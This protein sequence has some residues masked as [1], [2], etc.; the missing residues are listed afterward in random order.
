ME[1]LQNDRIFIFGWTI[2]LSLKGNSSSKNE[3]VDTLK[4]KVSFRGRPII[5]ADIKHFT[6]ID[7]GHFQNRFA[8]YYY[9][10][11]I[12]IFL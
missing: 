8:D 4:F 12:I 10:F 11:I 9:F 6:I 3:N 5:G 2:S 7:I 1:S